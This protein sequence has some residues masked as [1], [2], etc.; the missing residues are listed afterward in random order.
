MLKYL[1]FLF[2][3]REVGICSCLKTLYWDR[4]TLCWRT[5]S[6]TPKTHFPSII[7]YYFVLDLLTAVV[8]GPTGVPELSSEWPLSITGGKEMLSAANLSQTQQKNTSSSFPCSATMKITKQLLELVPILYVLFKILT[9]GCSALLDYFM[10]WHSVCA[11]SQITITCLMENYV[12][13]MQRCF[14]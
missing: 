12:D 3:K 13:F 14:L 4:P 9:T 5:H 2:L 11:H 6:E 1:C 8:T 7:L 10:T